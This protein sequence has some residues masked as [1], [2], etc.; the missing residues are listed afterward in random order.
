VNL[1]SGGPPMTVIAV[2]HSDQV[3]TTWF[4]NG[5]FLLASAEQPTGEIMIHT[6]PPDALNLVT[7]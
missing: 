1:K 2:P 6:W 5:Q 3:T 7:K 4:S